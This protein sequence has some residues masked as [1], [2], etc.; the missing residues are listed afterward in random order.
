MSLEQFADL[1]QVPAE[2]IR[3]YRDAGLLDPDRDGL[4][5]DY[6]VL[7][8]RLILIRIADGEPF[9]QVVREIRA[10]TTDFPF[11]QILFA[12]ADRTYSL[13]EAARA[14]GFQP[15]AIRD[16][17]TAIGIPLAWIGETDIEHLRAIRRI[18]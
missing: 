5:D 13:E 3:Q 9:D 8:L 7:R 10:G 16:L 2:D 6:D 14:T 12:G 1:A 18:M 11:V 15:E 4:F 17:W